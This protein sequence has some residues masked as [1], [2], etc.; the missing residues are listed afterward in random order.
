MKTRANDRPACRSNSSICVVISLALTT[1]EQPA[2]TLPAWT[3]VRELSIG[4]ESATEY[5]LTDV[6][7][8]DIGDDGSMYVVHPQ[9]SIIRVFDEDGDFVRYVGRPGAGPGEFEGLSNA[10]LLGD[11]LWASDVASVAWFTLDGELLRDEPV[12]Y[13]TDRMEF[14]PR[15]VEQRLSDGSFAAVPA[16]LPMRDPSTW[17]TTYPMFAAR[18][19]GSTQQVGEFPMDAFRHFIMPNG[20]PRVTFLPLRRTFLYAYHPAGE[21][22]VFV[23][24]TAAESNQ[25][26]FFRVVRLGPTGDTIYARD[27]RYDP[28][29]VPQHVKDSIFDAASGEE[30]NRQ[31]AEVVEARFEAAPIPD[32]HP[33]V[34][35]VAHATDGSTWLRLQGTA[36]GEWIVLDPEGALSARAT[37]P[38]GLQILTIRDSLVWGVELDEN[39]VPSVVRYR[40]ER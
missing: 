16:W 24:Q 32:Y 2:A 14:Q 12:R 8:I 22:I 20:M 15:G 40:I 34:E 10:G 31:P 9:E 35:S 21:S 17:P 38:S 7:G 33:P 13:S 1:C 11:T 19:D 5:A 39:D 26:A 27:V 30:P 37:G 28:I 4:N 29:A 18:T 3:L 6:R 23:Q 25:P 36:S